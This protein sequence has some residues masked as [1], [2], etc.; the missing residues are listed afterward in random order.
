MRYHDAEIEGVIRVARA[1]CALDELV[2]ST[3]SYSSTDIL[4]Q[5]AEAFSMR[6]LTLLEI[7]LQHEERARRVAAR[8]R[9]ARRERKTK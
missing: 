6:T 2:T 7:V 8:F 3:D 5:L 1:A 9:A 4:L